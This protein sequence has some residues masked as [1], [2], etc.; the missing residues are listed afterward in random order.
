MFIILHIVGLV[1]ERRNFSALAMELC[2]SCINPSICVTYFIKFSWLSIESGIKMTFPKVIHLCAIYIIKFTLP[3][4][5]HCHY[6]YILHYSDVTWASWHL[7]SPA[8]WL[9]FQQFVLTNNKE[10]IKSSHDRPLWGEST[11]YRWIPLTKVQ[12]CDKSFH[13]MTSSWHMCHKSLGICFG[14][15]SVLHLYHVQW[16]PSTETTSQS[17]L[18]RQVISHI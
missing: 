6:Y 3:N 8:T 9:F 7:K 14:H 12:W 17:G 10:N 18:N 11:D 5:S 15:C 4:Y 16:H 2:L 1:Q 13:V